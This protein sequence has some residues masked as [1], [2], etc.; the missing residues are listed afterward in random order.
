MAQ[1]LALPIPVPLQ[2]VGPLAPNNHDNNEAVEAG[3][4]TLFTVLI[5]LKQINFETLHSE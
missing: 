4:K 1:N 2:G 3:W 5:T